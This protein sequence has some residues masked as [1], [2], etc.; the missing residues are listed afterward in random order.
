MYVRTVDEMSQDI[1]RTN[2]VAQIR[3]SVCQQRSYVVDFGFILYKGVLVGLM[4]KSELIMFLVQL[5]LQLEG[6][7]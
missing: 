6:L 3:L 4:Q 1:C 7:K 5:R 2:I